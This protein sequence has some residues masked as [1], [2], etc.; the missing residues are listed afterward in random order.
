[1]SVDV[2][3]KTVAMTGLDV[4]TLIA[5][6]DQ[7]GLG[8]G[9][10]FVPAGE[11]VAEFGPSTQLGSTVNLL[12]EQLD[13][14]TALRDVVGALP[15]TTPLDQYRISSGFGARKDPVNGRKARHRG[16]DF[17]APTRTAVYATAPGK[18][19]F[20]GWRG[21]FGRTIEI[22]HGHGIRTRYGHL[23]KILVEAGQDVGHRQ[24]IGLVGSS[25][26]ST[27]PHVH[28]EI[29]FKG[30]AQNPMRFLKAGKYVFKG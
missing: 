12:D 1:L 9:G 27:G 16:I 3:E 30:Q 14:W 26:R 2:I 28:Y 23:R 10:P 29:R 22:D 25:G 8:R 19:V 11:G 17:A 24:K 4:D 13:R 18:V 21:R 5:Q 20:A 15:L 7:S 6:V